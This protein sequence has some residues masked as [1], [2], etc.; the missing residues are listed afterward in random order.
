MGRKTFDP[1]AATSGN[2]ELYKF[3]SVLAQMADTV[4]ITDFDGV[5]EYVNPAFESLT[6]YSSSEVIGEKN[7]ILKSG[8]HDVEFYKKVWDTILQGEVFQGTFINRKKNREL[9][10]ETKTITPILDGSGKIV[11]F[12]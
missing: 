7:N 4:V 1:V 10:F 5:I 12:V 6:G 9:F 11:N 2:W 3:S 8:L